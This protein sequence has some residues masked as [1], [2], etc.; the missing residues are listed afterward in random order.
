MLPHTTPRR[1][2]ETNRRRSLTGK[3]ASSVGKQARFRHSTPP[4]YMLQPSRLA[5]R[6]P[7]NA[8][9]DPNPRTAPCRRKQSID[10]CLKRAKGGRL[11]DIGKG[12]CNGR[13]PKHSRPQPIQGDKGQGLD[14]SRTCAVGQR[15]DSS[16]YE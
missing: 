15:R 13:V 9:L 16:N 7:S 10:D 2:G 14:A 4:H 5:P 6:D 8:S 3:Q 11:E 1:G 12:T